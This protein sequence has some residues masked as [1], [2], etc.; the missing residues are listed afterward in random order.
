[1]QNVVEPEID[2]SVGKLEPALQ[3]RT[4]STVRPPQ[5]VATLRIGARGLLACTWSECEK[6]EK[7]LGTRLL[8]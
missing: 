5:P 8:M 2:V 7:G 4:A 3:D 6:R 1:M